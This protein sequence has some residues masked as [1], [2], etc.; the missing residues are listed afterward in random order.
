MEKEALAYYMQ[1][2]LGGDSYSV[3]P[4]LIAS[5]ISII[6]QIIKLIYDYKNPQQLLDDV[7]KPGII[8]RIYLHYKISQILSANKS[9]IGTFKFMEAAR[10]VLENKSILAIQDLMNSCK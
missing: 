10:T 3:D 9:D 7:K 4:I 5:I 8:R 2:E 1:K 6:V